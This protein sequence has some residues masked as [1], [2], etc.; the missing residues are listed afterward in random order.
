MT[1][2][3]IKAT[4]AAYRLRVLLDSLSPELLREIVSIERQDGRALGNLAEL[5][6]E[7]LARKEEQA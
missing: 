2:D 7:T 3:S 5:C 6:R 1:V 4:T